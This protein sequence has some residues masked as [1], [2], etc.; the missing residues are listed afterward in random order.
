MKLR[1]FLSLAVSSVQIFSAPVRVFWWLQHL[2]TRIAT[3]WIVN[4]LVRCR[5]IRYD[6]LGGGSALR[7][8]STCAENVPPAGLEVAIS[9][10]KQSKTV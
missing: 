9:V 4:H 5:H 10:F 1:S 6:S 2:P 7:K 3:E 8:V